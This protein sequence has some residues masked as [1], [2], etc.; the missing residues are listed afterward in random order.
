M[1]E[2]E[3]VEIQKNE[4]SEEETER[5]R[6]CRCFLPKTDIFEDKDAIHVNLDMPGINENA[7][8]IT[9]EKNILNVRGY[10]QVQERGKFSP[11]LQEY[12]SGDYERSFR[13]SHQ[14]DRDNIEA[15]YKDGVL[16][17]NIPKIEEAKT[18]KITVKV[19]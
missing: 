2:Q 13:I 7:I 14:V 11:V 17:L 19:S 1:T 16:M 4:N 8:E 12:E 9:L 10:S 15:I 18:K 3:L 6:E 5:T